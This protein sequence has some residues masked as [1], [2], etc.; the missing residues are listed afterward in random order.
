MLEVVQDFVGRGQ[1]DGGVVPTAM[2]ALIIY[3]AALV[4]V[5]LGEKRFMGKSTAFDLILGVI[6]GSVVSRAIN[7]SAELLPTIAA[8]FVL[9]GLH[10]A[11][12]SLAFRS[13]RFGTLIK[14]RTRLLVKDGSVDWDEMK[15]SHTSKDDLLGALRAQARLEG[16]EEVKAAR[17]ERSGDISVIKKDAEP[18]VVSVVAQDGKLLI[19]LKMT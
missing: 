3:A 4:M 16:W 18:Q 17:L 11:L 15:A 14:G 12:A 13:D 9:V 8:G 7:G 10:W 2:R 5:R 1:D 6:L 19:T